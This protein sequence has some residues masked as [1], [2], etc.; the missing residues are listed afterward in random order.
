MT[1]VAHTLH[2]PNQNR[3]TSHFFAP[4]RRLGGE[5]SFGCVFLISIRLEL[6]CCNDAYD[7][8]D[9]QTN[10][11]INLLSNCDNLDGSNLMT[12]RNKQFL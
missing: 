3:I 5:V 10:G 8:F 9:I 7:I 1:I 4:F 12:T 6:Q 2:P 11:I